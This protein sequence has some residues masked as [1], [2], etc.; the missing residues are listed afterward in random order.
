VSHPRVQRREDVLWRRS[1]D[2]V[3]LLPAGATEPVT[4]AGSGPAVWELLTAPVSVSELAR[5]LAARYAADPATVEADV[6]ALLDRL[7]TLGVI[8]SAP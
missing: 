3:I 1:L 6:V 2:A 5:E 7:R 4:L 8:E